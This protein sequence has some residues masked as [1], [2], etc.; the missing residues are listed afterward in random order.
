MINRKNETKKLIEYLDIT[1]AGGNAEK[2]PI[3]NLNIKELSE[4]T[5]VLLNY[6]TYV[7][8]ISKEFMDVLGT[9]SSFDV[10][11]AHISNDLT[12]YAGELADCAESNLAIIEETTASM[13]QVNENID[14]TAKVLKDLTDQSSSLTDENNKTKQVINDV[15]NLKENVLK[16][17][18]EMK[19]QIEQLFTLIENID[20]MVQYVQGIANQ[21]N[22]LALNANIEAA[23]AGEHG[24]GFA[25]VA[26]EV[27]HLADTTK[28][29]LAGMQKF[30]EQVY[31]ASA[32]GKNSVD[33]VLESTEKIGEKIDI[34]SM[35][36]GENIEMLHQ[37]AKT[38]E[39]INE[40]M[41]GINR[42][43]MEVNNAM[44]Q[45]SRDAENLT[46]M[47]SA[48]SNTATESVEY[49]EG[50][51]EIDDKLSVVAQKL[52]ADVHQGLSMISNQE[53]IDILKKAKTAHEAWIESV[54]TMVKEEKV[55]PLQMN[56]KKCAFGHFYGVIP[57]K[58]SGLLELW[59]QIGDIHTRLHEKGPK[60][61]QCIMDKDKRGAE[62]YLAECEEISEKVMKALGDM[63]KEV[64]AMSAKGEQV[65]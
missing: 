42:V 2:V 7:G 24:K 44:E 57:I 39:N 15:E 1:M 37:V 13:H 54:R 60:V 12:E 27:G 19:K 33:K 16:D 23:R 55:H 53:V 30:M 61:V 41:E 58:A 32:L 22:L 17:S 14:E 63:Q 35:T 4:R 34:V 38:V 43:T 31:Q 50:V 29:Q 62:K 65:S 52:Y 56:P 49:A 36:V 64:E 26:D 3:N 18:R 59:K 51:E 11:L 6:K 46:Y 5:D 21:I 10:G 40:S 47:S 20:D 25:V 48:V 9:I 8:E 28:E 45:C